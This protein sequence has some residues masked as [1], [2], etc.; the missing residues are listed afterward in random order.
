MKKRVEVEP[1]S[2]PWAL[3]LPEVLALVE[4]RRGS[5]LGGRFR[6]AL[7][8][9]LAD[10]GGRLQGDRILAPPLP[11]SMWRVAVEAAC[12]PVVAVAGRNFVDMAIAEAEYAIAEAARAEAHEADA[13]GPEEESE[14]SLREETIEARETAPDGVREEPGAE[15]GEEAPEGS[16]EESRAEVVE[17]PPEIPKDTVVP[18]QDP[19]DDGS[20]E[21]AS[22]RS[23]EKQEIQPLSRARSAASQERRAVVRFLAAVRAGEPLPPGAEER[24]VAVAG[25]RA[26][27]VLALMDGAR[28]VEEIAQEAGLEVEEVIAV[29]DILVSSKAALRYVSRVRPTAGV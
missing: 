21:R 26:L 18:D 5:R 15:A 29:A 24:I 27:G 6:S 2:R 22:G 4:K 10:F 20:P 3:I 28:T 23:R 12:A 13:G 25:K 17:E 9:S 14:E 1:P 11:E 19:S 7:S 8:K 16:P